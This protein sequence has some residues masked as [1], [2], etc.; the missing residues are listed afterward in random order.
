MMITHLEEKKKDGNNKNTSFLVKKETECT[1]ML[2]VVTLR[3]SENKP[4]DVQYLA[5]LGE[6]TTFTQKGK[7]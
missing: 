5:L 4:T 6:K 3:K 7:N 1:Y 2:L